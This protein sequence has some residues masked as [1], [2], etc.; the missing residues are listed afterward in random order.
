MFFLNTLTV[1]AAVDL[2]N[3]Y[4]LVFTAN[5]QLICNITLFNKILE[6]CKVVIFNNL[7]SK[8]IIEN[9]NLSMFEIVS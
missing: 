2:A 9:Y 5:L 4:Y 6:F 8:I 1:C 7:N 3:L